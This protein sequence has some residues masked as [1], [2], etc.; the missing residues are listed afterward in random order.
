[1]GFSVTASHVIFFVAVLTAGSAA[2]DAYFD[3]AKAENQSRIEWVR[4]SASQVD[5]NLTLSVNQCSSNCRTPDAPVFRLDV[6]NSGT[7]VVDYRNFTYIIDGRA[8]TVENV[9]SRSIV[10]PSSVSGTDLIL[11][12]ETMRIDFQNMPLTADYANDGSDVPIQIVTL[13]GVIG[14]R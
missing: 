4:A 8:H 5:T 7:T 12:G 1:M 11:P 14:R 9:T 2:M 10:S 3:V 6:R 13:D